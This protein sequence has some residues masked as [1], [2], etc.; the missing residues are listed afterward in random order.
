M[1]PGFPVHDTISNSRRR[2]EYMLSFE[3]VRKIL[4]IEQVVIGAVAKD[5]LNVLYT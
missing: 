2:E 1:T 4:S 3:E 5:L